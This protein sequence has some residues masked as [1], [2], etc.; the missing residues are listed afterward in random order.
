M[1]LKTAQIAVSTTPVELTI[2]DPNS[3]ILI[4]APAA[5]DLFVGGPTVTATTGYPVR[6]GRE[7]AFD[8]TGERLYAVVA[9]GTATAY[10]LRTG[11]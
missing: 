1:A 4:Q 9:T 10:V 2:K 5:V 6:A 11:V 7:V 8:F 3:T